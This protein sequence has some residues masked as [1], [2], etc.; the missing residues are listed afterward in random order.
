MGSGELT[1]QLCVLELGAVVAACPVFVHPCGVV[2]HGP[3][4]S[5]TI[6]WVVKHAL[7]HA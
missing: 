5:Y 3:V 7:L 4:V 6:V 2:D 1:R